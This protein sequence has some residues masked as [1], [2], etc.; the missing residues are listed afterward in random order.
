VP[1]AVQPSRVESFFL[2][3]SEMAHGDCSITSPL[4][5]GQLQ[6]KVGLTSYRY[7]WLKYINLA[8]AARANGRF[9]V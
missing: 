9:S 2:K 6:L 5:E 4:G 8:R 1:S 3:M 7:L